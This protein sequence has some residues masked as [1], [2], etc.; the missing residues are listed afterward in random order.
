MDKGSTKWSW[1]QKMISNEGIKS[2]IYPRKGDI[3]VFQ[4][5]SIVQEHQKERNPRDE[6]Y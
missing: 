1:L 4:A 3:H 5:L 6:V 2:K